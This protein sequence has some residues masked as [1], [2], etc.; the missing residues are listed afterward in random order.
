ML[1]SPAFRVLSVSAHRVLFRIEIELAHHGGKENG[2]LP[3][4]YDDF[5]RYGVHRHCISPAIRELEALG[6]LR[7]TERGRAGNAEF[8]SPNRFK[9][10]YRPALD[11]MGDGT[12]DWR[13]IETTKQAIEV[14]RTA[15]RSGGAKIQATKIKN[16]GGG[17]CRSSGAAITTENGRSPVPEITTPPIV[18]NSARLSISR[19]GS[20]SAPVGSA[21]ASEPSRESLLS[22]IMAS[23][24]CN[25]TE[26]TDILNSLPDAP[27]RFGE[28][29]E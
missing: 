1:E 24:G 2:R 5:E 4:T 8:R 19:D 14:A 13:R 15:R 29:D 11:V 10:T 9:L 3:V 28:R 27:S 16:A 25:R 20:R 22:T 7:I 12:H 23:H 21:V 17:K 18:Q 6:F 26:A